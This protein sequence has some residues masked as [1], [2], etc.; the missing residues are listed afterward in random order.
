MTSTFGKNMK[1]ICLIV[2]AVLLST[3]CR[4]ADN[5]QY[6]FKASEA[7]AD[8]WLEVAKNITIKKFRF[9]ETTWR[10]VLSY[11]E[12]ASLEGDTERMGISIFV[13]EKFQAEFE[14]VA[15]SKWTMELADNLNILTVFIEAPPPE[16]T[17]FPVAPRKIAVIPQRLLIRDL[18][19]P[20]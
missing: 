5:A 12:K 1:A 2:T 10:D 4:G 13:P 3:V 9:Q 11:I 8:K 19:T 14:P 7:Y 15:N 6:S 17:Y 16:W 20:K 18:P